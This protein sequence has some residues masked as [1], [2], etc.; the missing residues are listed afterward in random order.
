VEG[1][2]KPHPLSPPQIAFDRLA[3][4]TGSLT[5]RGATL[6]GTFTHLRFCQASASEVLG[7]VRF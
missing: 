5:F 4:V 6:A 2:E 7:E 1:T 3:F